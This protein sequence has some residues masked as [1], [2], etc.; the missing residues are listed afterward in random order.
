MFELVRSRIG[1]YGS[2]PSYW[3]VLE[4]HDLK[5]L[6]LKLNGLSKK[7]Y[8]TND[9]KSLMMWFTFL[10]RWA[11]IRAAKAIDQRF[12]GIVDIISLPADTPGDLLQDIRV[13]ESPGS[14]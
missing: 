3:P 6:G 7:G 8:G 10:Q 12:G 14:S 5:D 4:A 11:D 1:F 9:K 13:L 2:T